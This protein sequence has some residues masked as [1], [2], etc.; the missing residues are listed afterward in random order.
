MPAEL[1]R[2]GTARLAQPLRPF[3]HRRRRD[4]IFRDNALPQVVRVRLGQLGG[5]GGFPNQAVRDSSC[6]LERGPACMG[7][8]VGRQLQGDCRAAERL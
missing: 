1:G 2:R 8:C 4:L 7:H 6:M 5:I 3:H